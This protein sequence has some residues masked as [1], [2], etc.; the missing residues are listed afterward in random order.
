MNKQ[1]PEETFSSPAHQTWLA[2]RKAQHPLNPQP[3]QETEVRWLTTNANPTAPVWTEQH[4]W[5]M[6]AVPVS[7]DHILPSASPCL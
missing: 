3:I 1:V 2:E 7:D 4:G 6:H 5:K